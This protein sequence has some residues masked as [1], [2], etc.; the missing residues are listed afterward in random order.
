[1]EKRQHLRVAK[2]NLSV[3]VA[4]G[5]GFFRGLVS[6]ISRFGVCITDLSKQLDGDVG[7]MTI[8]VSGQGEHFKMNVRPRWYT[9][10]GARKSVGVEIMNIPWGWTEFV[11]NFEPAIENDVWGE[12]RL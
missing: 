6:D 1:M 11:M 4:Y 5:T 2:D 9:H 3:D 8:V 7:K 10:G 12:V